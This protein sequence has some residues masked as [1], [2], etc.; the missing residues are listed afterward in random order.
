[1]LLPAPPKT[2]LFNSQLV[3][4]F[5]VS[6]HLILSSLTFGSSEFWR[7]EFEVCLLMCTGRL[8]GWASLEVSCNFAM[9]EIVPPLRTSHGYVVILSGG[10]GTARRW[11]MCEEANEQVPGYRFLKLRCFVACIEMQVFHAQTRARR[12]A[13]RKHHDDD[14]S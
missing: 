3:N 9:A 11:E 1:M 8:H 10:T 5:T 13:F 7:F 14:T 2:L 6:L 4:L 12:A